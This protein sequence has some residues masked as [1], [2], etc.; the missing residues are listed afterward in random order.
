MR[1]E[2]KTHAG[3]I[4]FHGNGEAKRRR[5]LGLMFSSF[6]GMASLPGRHGVSGMR[7]GGVLEGVGG[8][9]AVC[10]PPGGMMRLDAN[11]SDEGK[12]GSSCSLLLPPRLA[13]A[14]MLGMSRV[15]GTQAARPGGA[16]GASQAGWKRLEV[17]GQITAHASF[18]TPDAATRPHSLPRLPVG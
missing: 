12:P 4:P 14:G 1:D 10:P 13:S 2:D 6:Q 18:P 7:R 5:S 15:C 17:G 8:S 16:R 9:R 3:S 11:E